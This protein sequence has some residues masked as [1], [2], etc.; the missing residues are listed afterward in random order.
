[1]NQSAEGKPTFPGKERGTILQMPADHPVTGVGMDTS[2]QMSGLT[3]RPGRGNSARSARI[4][5]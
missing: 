4:F 3:T 2:S 5:Y 1:M